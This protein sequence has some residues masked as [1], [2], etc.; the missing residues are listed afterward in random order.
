MIGLK[1]YAHTHNLKIIE[2]LTES[3]VL[4]PDPN[5]FPVSSQLYLSTEQ[6]QRKFPPVY[7]ATICNAVVHGGTNLICAEDGVI[8]HD[9]YDF[10]RDYTSEELGGRHSI[11]VKRSRIRLLYEDVKPFHMSIAA[12]FVD[13]C[14][15]NYAHWLTEVL[16]RIASFCSLEKYAHVPLIV[17]EGLHEN[18]MQ[19]LYVIAGSNR[20]IVVLPIGR[21]IKVESLLV[22]SVAG[23]IPFERR[24]GCADGHSHGTF[25]ASALRLMCNTVLNYVE[26]ISTEHLPQKIYLERGQTHRSVTNEEQ[27]KAQLVKLGFSAIR[28]DTLDFIQQA[29][30]LRHAKIVV[31]ATGAALANLIF[32]NIDQSIHILIAKLPGMPYMYWPNMVSM[33]SL[34][35]N[36][37][38]GEASSLT[39]GIHA[40][41]YIDPENVFQS[42]SSTSIL[43]CSALKE[44]D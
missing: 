27:I 9:L 34:R 16:T 8:H 43:C 29:A 10:R 15:Q 5:V 24:N 13:A 44:M 1:K 25:S 31:G 17:D 2:V 23:Y 20:Q 41:F 6:S 35:V 28:L 32:S 3:T 19:S 18:I 26:K 33:H 11:D 42:I 36:Y 37:V 39:Q 40:N 4:T 7:V 30:F 21:A 38:L 22:T 12:C 14:A